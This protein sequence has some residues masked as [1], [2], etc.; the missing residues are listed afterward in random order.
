VPS[1]S[2]QI[3]ST[4]KLTT[5]QCSTTANKH[6]G[7]LA[8][9]FRHLMI[10]ASDSKFPTPL[11]PCLDTVPAR[12]RAVTVQSRCHLFGCTICQAHT[13]LPSVVCRATRTWATHAAAG[14]SGHRRPPPPLRNSCQQRPPTHR[15]PC[16][17]GRPRGRSLRPGMAPRILPSRT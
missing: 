1:P 15:N 4:Q 12:L 7:G 3:S 14:R 6:R 17:L 16:S 11:A 10:A 9:V 5:L 8:R 2:L 13:L